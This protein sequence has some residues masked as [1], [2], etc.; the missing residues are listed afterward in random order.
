MLDLSQAIKVIFKS[1]N[2]DFVKVYKQWR[3]IQKKKRKSSGGAENWRQGAFFF[4]F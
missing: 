1:L 4:F 2:L 3:C